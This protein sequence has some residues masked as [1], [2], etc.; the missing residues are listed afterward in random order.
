MLFPPPTARVIPVRVVPTLQSIFVPPRYRPDHSTGSHR[1]HNHS[2]NN[3]E[4]FTKDVVNAGISYSDALDGRSSSLL[5]EESCDDCALVI[6]GLIG[7]V[8]A[9]PHTGSD[10]WRNA[11]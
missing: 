3:V 5:P 8:T 11:Y 7:M 2:A 6:A 9:I 1:L 4:Q 10:A